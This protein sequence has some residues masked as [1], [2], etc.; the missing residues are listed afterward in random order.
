MSRTSP[1]LG[2]P[3]NWVLFVAV[4]S[5]LFLLDS[6][7]GAPTSNTSQATDF[8]TAGI[9][10]GRWQHDE[11]VKVL[12]FALHLLFDFNHFAFLQS[13]HFGFASIGKEVLPYEFP[14]RLRREATEQDNN[15][16]NENAADDNNSKGGGDLGACLGQYKG[17]F[18]ALCVVNVLLLALIIA[19]GVYLMMLRRKMEAEKSDIEKSR[20]TG[21]EKVPSLKSKGKS[22][23][24]GHDDDD[25]SN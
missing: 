18:I 6:V 11:F 4:V 1:P 19:L 8:A 7:N 14:L 10:S 13:I 20:D 21:Y 15:S 16:T 17:L 25:E 12:C 24:K 2:R 3:H 22:K 5:A 9:L 23:S